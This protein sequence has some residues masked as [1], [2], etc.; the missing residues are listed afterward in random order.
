MLRVCSRFFKFMT[1]PH[2]SGHSRLVERGVVLLPEKGLANRGQNLIIIVM[3]NI[4]GE[5]PE[6]PFERA[7]AVQASR[8]ACPYASFHCLFG[9][10]LHGVPG[11]AA[12]KLRLIMAPCFP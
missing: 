5:V 1:W 3:P 9:Q 11:T 8:A 10:M 4:E 6:D 7:R 12:G 2:K